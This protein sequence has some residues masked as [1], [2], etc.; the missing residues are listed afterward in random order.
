[1]NAA[2]KRATAAKLTTI[3][4]AGAADNPDDSAGKPL[5]NLRGL[6]Y[7]SES[8]AYLEAAVASSDAAPTPDMRAGFAK[9]NAVLASTLQRMRRLKG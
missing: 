8:Y 6:T 5:Q 1:M 4:G 3:V 9:L 2:L 7:L